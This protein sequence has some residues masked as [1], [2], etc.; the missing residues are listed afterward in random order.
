M[1]RRQCILA[2][3]A[4]LALVATGCKPSAQEGKP[5]WMKPPA[6]YQ[7]AKAANLTFNEKGL[8]SFNSMGAAER[9]AFVE[10]LKKAPGSFAGQAIVTSG[11]GVSEHVPEYKFGTWELNASTSAILYEITIKYALYT[12][13]ELGRGIARNR[14]V[15]FSGTIIGVEYQGSNKP[16]ELTVRVKVKDIKTLE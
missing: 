8:E 10:H 14:A 15:E 9:E 6:S 5:Q 1:L 3:S 12:T 4:G 13:P 16:R 11:T 2:L 7:P